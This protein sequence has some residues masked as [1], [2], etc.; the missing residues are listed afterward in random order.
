MKLCRLLELQ[1][2]VMYGRKISTKSGKSSRMPVT[3]PVQTA[4]L[5]P[6]TLA[7]QMITISTAPIRIAGPDES[8]KTHQSAVPVAHVLS[9]KNCDCRR[10]PTMAPFSERTTD[11]PSQ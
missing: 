2:P 4:G 5:M 7:A 6:N 10:K 11:Q 8:V 3:Y 9:G 1:S